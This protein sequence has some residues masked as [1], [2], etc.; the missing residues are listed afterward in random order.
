M[1]NDEKLFHLFLAVVFIQ[2]PNLIAITINELMKKKKKKL[3]K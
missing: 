2:K 3:Y 1:L